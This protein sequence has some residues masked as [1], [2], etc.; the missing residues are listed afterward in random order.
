MDRMVT[1]QLADQHIPGYCLTVVSNGAVVFQK[2]YGFA[3]LQKQ[4]PVTP[5]TVFGIGSLTKTFTALTLLTLVDKGLVNLDDPVSKYVP[6]L[7]PDYQ[8]LKIRQLASMVAGVP[9]KAPRELAW[10]EQLKIL[11][12][13]PLV[14]KPGSQYLYSNYSYR[15]LGSVIANVTGRD[16][17][18]VVREVINPLGMS[19]T[20]TVFSLASTGR[21]AL[22]YA[23]NM[24]NGPLREIEYKQP[25]V[26]FS[27]GMIATSSEDLTKYVQA[28]MSRQILSEQGY[29]TLWYTRPPLTTGAPSPWA[30]GWKS[31]PDGGKNFTGQFMVTM[32][33]GVP[34]VASNIIIL[35]ESRSAVIA[36]CNLRKPSVYAISRQAAQMVFGNG[37]SADNEEPA[38]EAHG[39]ND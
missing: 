28:L 17:L 21:V 1:Q 36:L 24:G 34:G 6:D 7:P 18:E 5:S 23:D 39:D 31:A 25:A 9:S 4:V 38:T 19:S 33:G 3:D 11:N 22:P 16:Y 8:P 12:Q 15:L 29:R 32:N 37:S 30:F 2:A 27:A 13:M 20:G 14:S 10:R 26:Q 35:P